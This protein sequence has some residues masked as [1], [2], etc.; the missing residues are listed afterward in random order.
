M[1]C[2]SG[3][4][5]PLQPLITSPPGVNSEG[6]D[7]VPGLVQVE[8]HFRQKHPGLVAGLQHVDVVGPGEEHVGVGHHDDVIVF[9]PVPGLDVRRSGGQ[10]GEIYLA[11][12]E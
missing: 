10:I 7:L 11:S 1:F 8:N 4:I 12:L 5:W 9:H 2:I 3:G 6:H